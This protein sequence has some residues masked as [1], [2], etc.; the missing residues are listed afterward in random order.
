MSIAE[1]GRRIESERRI[2]KERYK[3]RAYFDY[4][5]ADL[6]GIS[7]SRLYSSTA[8]IPDISDIYPTLFSSKEK[9]ELEQQKKNELSI[10]RFKQFAQAF[11]QKFNQEVGK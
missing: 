2:E 6:I 10:I 4:N 11:N 1:L 9:E 7:I 8:A 5:L 3:E